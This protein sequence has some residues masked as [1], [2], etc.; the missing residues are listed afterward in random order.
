[1]TRAELLYEKVL[2]RLDMTKETGEE[3]LQDIIQD[4]LEEAGR[5]EYIPLGDKIRIS[6]DLF[7]SFRRL[8]ILQ[9]LIEDDSITEIMVNGTENIFYEKGGR[10]FKSDR[11]FLSEERLNDVIQQIVGEAN[12]YV[13]ETSPIVDARL[14]DGSRVNVV[15]KP[16]AVN[17]PIMTIRKFPAEGITMKQL[18]RMGSLTEEAAS[19]IRRLVRAKY[20]IFV[21]GGTGAGKTTFL[22]AMSDYIPKDERIITIEDNAELQI[23]GVSNLVSLEARNAN[24]EGEGA[25]T[26]R[27][28]IRSA[29]RMRPDRIIV[30]EVRGEETV[31]MI[32]SAMLNGH[33]GSMSTGHA[34]N[35]SDMLH[36]LET[37]MMMGIDLPL[38]AIQRQ[39]SSA[40]D[41][42]IHLGRLRDKSR[43]VLQIEEVLGYCEGRI[44]TKTLYEFREEG[45][46]DEKVKGCLM[47]TGEIENRDKLVAAGYQ[48]I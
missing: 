24:M 14:Q 30:G 19:F 7:N 42:I 9:D 4:V 27:D 2:L 8:D 26:I 29:L 15:L 16:V 17:G 45:M 13:N 37:M 23:Q 22:N 33:S 43:H 34:N 11:R 25:V 38:Q 32:S 31:D 5:E 44:Q 3:E 40:L 1:M 18:V 48:K 39:I 20:N 21:S 36:R 6:R 41:I 10:L 46:E 28:L 35:P 47:K 12:R